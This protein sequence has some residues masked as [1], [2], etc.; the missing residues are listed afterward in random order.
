MLKDQSKEAKAIVKATGDKTRSL[1]FLKPHPD[2]PLIKDIS[3]MEGREPKPLMDCNGFG[4]A[5]N[6]LQPI[7]ETDKEINFQAELF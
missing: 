6:D 5:V 4:C 2:Y 7:N 3:M 1:V